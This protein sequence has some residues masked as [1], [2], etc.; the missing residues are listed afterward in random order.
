MFN[1]HDVTS[2]TLDAMADAVVTDAEWAEAFGWDGNVDTAT[3]AAYWQQV[4]AANDYA[5]Y[6][7]AKAMAD[8]DED[9]D[10][11]GYEP[12]PDGEP[13]PPAGPA[14]ARS[15]GWWYAEFSNQRASAMARLEQGTWRAVVELDR[16]L[17]L[18]GQVP[19]GTDLRQCP[20]CETGWASTLFHDYRYCPTCDG[21]GLVPPPAIIT[22]SQYAP[23]MMLQRHSGELPEAA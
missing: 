3:E 12:T 5:D 16:R 17:A 10:D 20:D 7:E 21:V 2:D 18:L 11:P 4:D 9:D 23:A 15:R 13:D 14:A 8:L 6:L 1:P 19:A 22:L